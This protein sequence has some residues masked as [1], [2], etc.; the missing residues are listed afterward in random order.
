VSL[1]LNV[2]YP[3]ALNGTEK[4]TEENKFK[5]SSASALNVS[6]SQVAVALGK[7]AGPRKI[8]G[9]KYDVRIVVSGLSIEIANSVYAEVKSG[10]FVESVESAVGQNITL[11]WGPVINHSPSGPTK[12][13]SKAMTKAVFMYW[14]IMVVL[15]AFY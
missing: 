15:L 8:L 7:T 10:K 13:V 2:D 5:G 12:A 3:N 6:V 9:I 4:A 14:N 1:T 11:F